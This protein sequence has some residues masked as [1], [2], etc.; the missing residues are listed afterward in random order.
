MD[1]QTVFKSSFGYYTIHREKLLKEG[2]E[3]VEDTKTKTV[4]V[5][6]DSL[7]INK[8]NYEHTPNT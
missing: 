3:I 2:F 8:E 6:K 4:F 7:L 5:K 1:K